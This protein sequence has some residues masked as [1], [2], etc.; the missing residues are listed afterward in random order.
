MGVEQDAG[1][2]AGQT[3]HIDDAEAFQAFVAELP[4][5]VG[6]LVRAVDALLRQE[7]PTA[8][9]VLWPH[10]RTVGYGSA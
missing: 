10:Q 9:Q 6:G 4:A 5:V 3:A 2:R 7:N 1:T 8:T